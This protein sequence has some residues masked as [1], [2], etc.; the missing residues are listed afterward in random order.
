MTLVTS[1]GERISTS[2]AAQ[3]Q[4]GWHLED[5]DTEESLMAAGIA[6]QVFDL[7]Y[8]P[9]ELRGKHGQWAKG[10]AQRTI[11][12]QVSPE[13]RLRAAHQRMAATKA[14][15]A[16][17]DVRQ[18]AEERA[19]KVVSEATNELKAQHEQ[20]VGDLLTKV[21]TVDA[22]LAATK[23]EADYESL[24]KHRVKLVVEGLM[25]IGSGII[26]LIAARMGAPE[27][28]SV[29]APVVPFLAQAIIEFLKRL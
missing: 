5:D 12:S 15:S 24:H 29:L 4:R 9:H 28:V 19:H 2:Q 10:G 11:S 16:P 6:A 17:P 27:I 20:I 21:Q 25:A 26:A 7:A 3:L 23:V 8:N 1:S 13:M 22:K 18:I 14:Q